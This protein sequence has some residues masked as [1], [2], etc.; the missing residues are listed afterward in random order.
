MIYLLTIINN[1]DIIS[2]LCGADVLISP[3]CTIIIQLYNHYCEWVSDLWLIIDVSTVPMEAFKS[4]ENFSQRLI[5][6]LLIIN[7]ESIGPI[8]TSKQ[9]KQS[10]NQFLLWKL[11]SY[12]T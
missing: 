11:F 6:F 10:R 2:K 4:V 9:D 8:N 12:N 1:H 5:L 3:C 7:H